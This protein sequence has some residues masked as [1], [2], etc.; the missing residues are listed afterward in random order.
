MIQVKAPAKINLRLKVT[1]RRPDGYHLLEMVMVKLELADEIEFEI[2]PEG[3]S[4]EI[5]PNPPLSKG[6]TGGFLIPTDRTNTLWKVALAVQKESG[7]RFGIKIS[8]QK[9]IPT[10]AG[11]GGGSSD[12]AALLI[13]LNQALELGWTGQKLIQ[14][15]VKIGADVPFFLAPGAQR[16]TGIGELLTPYPCNP[17]PLIL[18]NPGFP[19][20]TAEVYRWWDETS[21][22]GAPS[23]ESRRGGKGGEVR[24]TGAIV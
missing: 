5:P 14:I 11:L 12:A 3:I 16:V 1:G 7:K 4:I 19:V 2:V 24:L 17:L 9:R 22:P 20:S 21:P 6:G 15:G 8:L 13:A 10:A 23:P 18:I